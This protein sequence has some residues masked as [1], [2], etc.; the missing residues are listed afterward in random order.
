VAVTP[1][2]LVVGKESMRHDQVQFILGSRHPNVQQAPL[3]LDFFG[4]ACGH[5]RWDAAIHDIQDAD[6]LPFLAFGGMN[7]RKNGVVFIEQRS[8]CAARSGIRRIQGDLG[9]KLVAR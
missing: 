7:R 5:V 3:F 2:G 9:E 6:H 4:C 8:A 1:F